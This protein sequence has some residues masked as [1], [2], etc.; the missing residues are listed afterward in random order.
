MSCPS[1]AFGNLGECLMEVQ[2]KMFEIDIKCETGG[3]SWGRFVGV[4][5]HTSLTSWRLF[6]LEHTVQQRETTGGISAGLKKQ[7]CAWETST[8]ARASC[9]QM[10][11]YPALCNAFLNNCE[12]Q[13]AAPRGGQHRVCN[14]ILCCVSGREQGYASHHCSTINMYYCTI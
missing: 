8:S 13:Q 2:Y 3:K 4:V 11:D 12:W 6:V 9:P 10:E 14:V 1:M 7:N 5:S